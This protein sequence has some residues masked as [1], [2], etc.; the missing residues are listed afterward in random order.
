[1]CYTP[2]DLVILPHAAEAVF[3]NMSNKI[4]FSIVIDHINTYMV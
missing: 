4:I 2:K 1:M 3:I